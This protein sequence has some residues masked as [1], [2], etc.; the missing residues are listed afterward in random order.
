MYVHNL[1][2]GEAEAPWQTSQTKT[3]SKP[4]SRLMWLPQLGSVESNPWNPGVV[5]SGLTLL[6]CTTWLLTDL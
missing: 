6:S 4:S 1:N 3:E 2:V 5:V